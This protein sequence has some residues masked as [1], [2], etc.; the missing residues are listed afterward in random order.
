MTADDLAKEVAIKLS[1]G[2]LLAIWHVLSSKVSGTPFLEGLSAEEKRT[3]WALEDLCE[4][5]LVENGV[6]SRPEGEWNKLVETA[7]EHVKS[8]PVEFLDP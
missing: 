2:H 5:G 7:M 4:R 6:N 8:I 3:L 1:V